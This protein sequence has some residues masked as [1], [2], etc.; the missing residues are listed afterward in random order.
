MAGKQW[1]SPREAAKELGYGLSER[2]VRRQIELG[3]LPAVAF[4]A[5]GRRTLRIDR[6]DLETFR[7]EFIRDGREI[8]RRW[9]A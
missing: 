1:L 9:Q 4:D 8:P 6:A 7:R 3:R 2:F 5:G